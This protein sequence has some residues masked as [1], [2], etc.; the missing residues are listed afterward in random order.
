MFGPLTFPHE[1]KPDTNASPS[2]DNV[3]EVV[4]ILCP[5]RCP[6]HNELLTHIF[7]SHK[8]VIADV[9]L[10]ADLNLYLEYWRVKLRQVELS[11]ICTGIQM[12]GELYHL[13]SD[14]KALVQQELERTDTSYSAQCMFC[15]HD[16]GPT[17]VHY[18]NHLS[19]F[20]NVQLGAPDTLV[21]VDKLLA[22]VQR[23]V[24]NLKCLF[25]E[26]TYKTRDVLK[27]HMRKKGHKRLNPHN[28]MY[29]QFYIDSYREMDR[30][31]KKN[32][33]SRLSCSTQA[34]P[35]GSDDESQ[36]SD[37]S[38]WTEEDACS[39]VCLF[40]DVTVHS[41]VKILDHMTG[42]HG[43][44]F[45]A[46]VKHLDFY[47]QVK[48]VNYLRR[49]IYWLSCPVCKTKTETKVDL[50]THIKLNNHALLPD[51]TLW[52]CPE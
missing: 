35:T 2:T 46:A 49:E 37:W 11:H 20:H 6:S 52:N 43:F 38:D 31:W 29:D 40:C 9:P 48:L 1:S 27:E 14:E 41:W 8:L 34:T 30:S 44:D 51:E 28:E 15:R 24:D 50:Y 19:E 33:S 5:E 36:D 12:N 21:Y 13:L 22:V 18:I 16:M 10:I 3:E 26:R 4:C 32:K 39:I 25:C 23:Q 7:V 42:E 47:Q 17:R 45:V